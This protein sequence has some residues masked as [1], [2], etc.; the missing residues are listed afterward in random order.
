M[1]IG[2]ELLG[3]V[4]SLGHESIQTK[5]LTV[6]LPLVPL[7][8]IYVTDEAFGRAQGYK[9][10]RLYG[11]SVL[12]AYL[13]NYLVFGAIAGA[14]WGYAFGS[15]VAWLGFA[16]LLVAW[17]ASLVAIGKLDP[18]ERDR[19]ECL[20]GA[21]GSGV[22]PELLTSEARNE[23]LAGLNEAPVGAAPWRKLVSAPDRLPAEQLVT[24]YALAR[25][26]GE[27]QAAAALWTRLENGEDLDA[28]TPEPSSGACLACGT[29]NR[30]DSDFCKSCG[31]R[32][33]DRELGDRGLGDQRLGDHELNDQRLGDRRCD[34][35]DTANRLDSEFCKG[36]GSALA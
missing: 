12:A 28:A 6:G 32:L 29:A 36:C 33:D 19:R 2:T 14:I 35:C 22:P 5:F 25:Y 16:L 13:R 17:I 34:D 24:L 9:L 8:S 27:P 15:A 3:E 1:R 30:S 20:R 11:P 26:G 23:L 4:E 10:E 21:V 31:T 18:I 7:E